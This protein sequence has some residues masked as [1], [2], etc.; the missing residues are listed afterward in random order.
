MPVPLLGTDSVVPGALKPLF[1]VG[2]GRNSVNRINRSS[3]EGD[4]IGS[5]YDVGVAMDRGECDKNRESKTPTA[6]S[7]YAIDYS[8]RLELFETAC[9]VFAIPMEIR[10]VWSRIRFFPWFRATLTS[11]LYMVTKDHMKKKK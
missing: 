8:R 2:R 11:W 7:I 3:A 6:E 10:H 9:T 5:E 1:S 4:P